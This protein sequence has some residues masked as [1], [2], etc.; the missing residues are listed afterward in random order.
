[1]VFEGENS[2]TRREIIEFPSNFEYCG[3]IHDPIKDNASNM[4]APKAVQ[5]WHPKKC[6]ALNHR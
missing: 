1:M 5:A 3:M 6:I 2:V 4:L